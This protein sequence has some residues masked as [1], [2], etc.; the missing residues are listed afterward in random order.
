MAAHLDRRTL[1]AAGLCALASPRSA[2]AA[3]VPLARH[4]APRP[5]PD[6]T[7][8]ARERK[9]L[10]LADFRGRVVALHVWATWCG[11]CRKEFPSLL[12]FD[13]AFRPHGVSLVALSIDRLGWP[14]I[15]RTLTELDATALPVYLDPTRAVPAALQIFGL[16]V[17]LVLDR[18]GREIAR[19]IGET[20]W[21]H[22][23]VA[24]LFGEALTA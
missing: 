8:D 5:V 14:I 6:I 19:L 23:L 2:L 10:T 7:F 21:D 9:G 20:D 22:P 11:S 16:P 17:T 3:G 13:A 15:E 12:R 4:A 24:A 18:D 1:L